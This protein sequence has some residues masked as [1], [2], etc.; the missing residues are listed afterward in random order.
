MLDHDSRRCKKRRMKWVRVFWCLVFSLG[1][2]KG[3]IVLKMS[4]FPFIRIL[5]QKMKEYGVKV[6]E[7]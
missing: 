7:S 5:F 1:F 3:K 6:G 4:N 2:K